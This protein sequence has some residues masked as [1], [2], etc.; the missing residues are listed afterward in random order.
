MQVAAEEFR[1]LK[2]E[3]KS[4]RADIQAINVDVAS[5][6]TRMEYHEKVSE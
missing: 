6:K 3:I 4:L 1:E 2:N 5:L